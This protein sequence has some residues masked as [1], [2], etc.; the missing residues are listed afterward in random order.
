MN[1][2]RM[3]RYTSGK[4]VIGLFLLAGAWLI[5]GVAV[6][7]AFGKDFISDF[8]IIY[9]IVFFGILL[10]LFVA[11]IIW[12]SR[13]IDWTGWVNQGLQEDEKFFTA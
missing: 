10:A 2:D 4:A 8:V 7:S 11:V 12:I 5:G 1:T 9:W 3:E 6:E 13:G